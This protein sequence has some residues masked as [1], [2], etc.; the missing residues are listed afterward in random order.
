[1]KHLKKYET[2][3][4]DVTGSV[5]VNYGD[6]KPELS[7]IVKDTEKYLE[8]NFDNIQKINS[9]NNSIDF[10]YDYNSKTKDNSKIIFISMNRDDLFYNIVFTRYYY[11]VENKSFTINI[12]KDEYNYLSNVIYKLDK[13]LRQ[14]RDKAK[15]EEISD[16]IDPKR[17]A[18]K[19][20]NL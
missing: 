13:K 16:I 20:F 5:E 6:K 2:W 3:T 11:G 14:N 7:K 9:S 18:A 4:T 12:T 10:N 1:M 8:D 19:K 17:V 15:I